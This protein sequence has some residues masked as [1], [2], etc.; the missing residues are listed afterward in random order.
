MVGEGCALGIT[1]EVI[2]EFFGGS[3]RRFGIDIP[4]FVPQRFD[5]LVAAPGIGGFS[6]EDEF[7]F[8]EGSF[9]G[10]Q[11][12]SAQDDAESFDMEEEA[13]ACG[14]PAGLVERQGSSG[15]EAVKVW[16]LSCWSQLWRTQVKPGVPCR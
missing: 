5:E 1:A 12:F 3:E 8:A 7:L 11:E 2:E 14:D 15:E 6:R 16:S 13:F 10:F 9:E 4:E